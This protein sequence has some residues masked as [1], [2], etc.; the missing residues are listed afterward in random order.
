MER[1]SFLPAMI[2]KWGGGGVDANFAREKIKNHTI[3]LTIVFFVIFP[4]YRMVTSNLTLKVK[5]CF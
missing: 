5:P 2:Q 4:G 1:R 3:S